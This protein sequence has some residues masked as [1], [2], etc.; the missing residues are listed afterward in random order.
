[1]GDHRRSVM[2][3]KKNEYARMSSK[4]LREMLAIITPAQEALERM[5]RV[6]AESDARF[7]SLGL[8]MSPAAKLDNGDI[9]KMIQDIRAELARRA[10]R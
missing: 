4:S 10:V 8:Q 2:P 6:N 9:A 5:D 7:A 1:M 3:A